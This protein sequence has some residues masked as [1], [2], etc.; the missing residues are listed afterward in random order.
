[1]RCLA[2]VI[3]KG[4][5]GGLAQTLPGPPMPP[6][7]H[8][9]RQFRV[10]HDISELCVPRADVQHGAPEE[11]LDSVEQVLGDSAHGTRVGGTANPL[12]PFTYLVVRLDTD[13]DPVAVHE[14][15]RGHDGFGAG[16]GHQQEQVDVGAFIA[17]TL[18]QRT[19]EMH[20]RVV[21]DHRQFAG[22]LEQRTHL[23]EQ[24]RITVRTGHRQEFGTDEIPRSPLLPHVGPAGL[25]ARGAR[26]A[27]ARNTDEP[28]QC[29]LPDLSLHGGTGGGD[30]PGQ[31]STCLLLDEQRNPWPAALVDRGGDEPA[32]CHAQRGGCRHVEIFGEDCAAVHFQ[33]RP[34]PAEHEQLPVQD[35]PGVTG[36]QF[37]VDALRWAVRVSAISAEHRW[38][39]KDDFA[40]HP[41]RSAHTGFVG[42][43]DIVA[44]DRDAD[45]HHPIGSGFGCRAVGGAGQDTHRL[46]MTQGGLVD[47][48]HRVW[49]APAVRGGQQCVFRETV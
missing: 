16:A 38:S 9:V 30:L 13:L 32:R 46:P 28:H 27:P 19:L 36:V 20:C 4:K 49:L 37:A 2:V 11:S 12:Q 14:E 40:Q 45:R 7:R 31:R 34:H 24:G 8:Q 39:G 15:N 43:P 3:E 6:R 25:S 29:V 23:F 10:G 47:P 42:D 44:R 18:G 21:G 5:G 1:M 35:E 17:E 33:A 41:L 26:Q 48:D 22:P